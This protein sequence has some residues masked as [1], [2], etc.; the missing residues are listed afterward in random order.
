MSTDEVSWDDW[1]RF[2]VDEARQ[3]D[4]EI[5]TACTDEV[6]PSAR[7]IVHEW[8]GELRDA[9]CRGERDEVRRLAAMCREKIVDEIAWHHRCLASAGPKAPLAEEPG[10]AS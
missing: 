6:H 10:D 1:D 8:R 2:V 9:A 7:Q 3:L 5:E 4:A